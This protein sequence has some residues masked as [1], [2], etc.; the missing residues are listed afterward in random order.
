MASWKEMTR[1]VRYLGRRGRFD[2]DLDAEVRFHLD[3]RAEELHAEGFTREE[4]MARARRE[5]G[6]AVRVLE[7]SREAWQLAWLE[8]TATNFRYAWR[9]SR[10]RPGFAAVVVLT[11]GL[12]IGA[13]SAVFSALDAVVL[14]PLP[15]P[16]GERL[17][18]ITQH[19]PE[20]PNTFVAP[21]RLADWDRLNGAFEAMT[22]FYTEDASETSGDVPE[23]LTQAF[24]APRFLEVWGIAPAIGSDLSFDG[25]HT[26]ALNAV[27]ISDRL[28]R[29]KFAA[30]P[31]VIGRQLRL[32]STSATIT[33]VMPASFV[34]PVRQVDVWSPVI[35]NAALARFRDATWYTVIGRLKPDVTIAQ[36]AANLATVQSQLAKQYPKSDGF[37]TVGVQP[38][39]EDIVGPLGNSLWVLFGSAA[40]LLV[41]ACVNV[42]ALLVVR[43]TERAHEMSVR[44]ALGASGSAL[45]GQAM[46]ETALLAVAGAALG[47]AIAAAA[48][49]VFHA[50][51]GNLPRIDEIRM[52]W[53]IVAYSLLTTVVVTLACGLVPAA[54]AMR[55]EASGALAHGGRTYVRGRSRVQWV[56]VA[57]QVS[58]AVVLLAG[59]GLLLRSFQ[60]LGRVAPGFE[61]SRVL[62]F[63]ISGSYGETTDYPRL[64]QRINRTLDVVRAI[65]GIR[66]AATAGALPGVPGKQQDEIQLLGREASEP[67]IAADSRYV[68]A[69]YFATVQI[70]IV[71]GASCPAAGAYA[72]VNQT[73]AKSYFPGTSP[74]GH[75]ASVSVNPTPST[76]VGVV[77]DAREQGLHRAPIPTVYW[78][79]SAPGPSPFF[80]VQ[81]AGPPASMTETLRR[82][83][84]EIEPL[85][86]VFDITPLA[87]RLDDAY[88]ENR[89]RMIALGSFAVT[90]VLLA[91]VGLYGT[92]SYLVSVRRRGV[93]LRLALGAGRGQIVRQF[94]GQGIGIAVVACVAGIGL[95][96]ASNRLL[97][98]MLFG[99]SPSDPE[100][101]MIVSLIVLTAAALASLIP[102]IR[103]A[104]VQPAQVLRDN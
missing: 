32:G 70:S 28:W 95:A 89:L 98:G 57:A 49:R 50:A 51:A 101:L 21:A 80:L 71:T 35:V 23:K 103:G 30:D 25:P 102:S 46:A 5:F 87:D 92:L 6:G 86:S 59:A 97:A 22:G 26:V 29:R 83:I 60:E 93:G 74:I 84:K 39:A 8:G 79:A 67:K 66:H 64:I 34:F 20:R 68:S 72:L 85:R 75:H 88:R 61:P 10:K 65:P 17:V 54:R 7:D 77:A 33:G 4:A 104:L 13:N 81:T 43:A 31:N 36:A 62:T 99:V 100:T 91:S 44:L 27:L 73:F 47:L 15:F 78:C 18:R 58:L 45:I 90:A 9:F 42:A 53:R 96:A 63:H 24:V 16:H 1:R 12:G 19:H 40:L 94:F 56:L 3:S 69:D 76:I 55:G 41:I 37:L 38:L 52:N 48:T 2:A 82:K 11:L 14:R